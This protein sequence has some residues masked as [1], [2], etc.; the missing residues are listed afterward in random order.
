MISLGYAARLFSSEFVRRF[1]MVVRYPVDYLAG[2]II[3]YLLF[4]GIF[5]GVSAN[6]GGA[7]GLDTTI[8]GMVIGAAMWLFTI[9][10][11]NQ[12][13]V[14]LEMEAMAG[15]LEQLFLAPV[16]FVNLMLVRSIVGYFYSLL[17]T[18]I[19]LV[20]IMA[21]TG[22]WL[23]FDALPALLVV[24]MAMVGVHGAALILGGLQLV[25]KRLGQLNT[26]AQFGFLFL[27]FPPV[28]KLSPLWQTIAYSF[29]LARGMTLLRGIVVD[30]WP[31]SDPQAQANLLSLAFNSAV[32]FALG[33]L[34]Y[35]LCERIA[36]EHGMLGHY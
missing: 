33:T 13:R 27:A 14:I 15:T 30:G 17:A 12:I 4:F 21:T 35:L 18:A 19:L 25:F 32:Y 7:P 26:I 34:F 20:L 29:P 22:R 5:T 3:L 1:W 9:A 28:E 31:L 8:D 6:M 10:V 11:F 23:S 16:R 2:V 24:T 36:K